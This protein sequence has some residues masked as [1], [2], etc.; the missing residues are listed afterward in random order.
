MGWRYPQNSS[1]EMAMTKVHLDGELVSRPID[2]VDTTERFGR[3]VPVLYENEEIHW[4]L[5]DP[6][7]YIVKV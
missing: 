5:G 4:A 7:P 2:Y 1:L 3:S 6:Y